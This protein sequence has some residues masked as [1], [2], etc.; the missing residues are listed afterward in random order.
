M[1]ATGKKHILSKRE[2]ATVLAALRLFQFQQ[3]EGP[4]W[5]ADRGTITVADMEQ[6]D[7]RTVPLTVPEIDALCERLNMGV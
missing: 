3:Q 5:T 2:L 6:F 1:H 7:G 4:F